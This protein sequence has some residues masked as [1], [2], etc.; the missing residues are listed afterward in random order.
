VTLLPLHQTTV[1]WVRFWDFPRL[2]ICAI[3]LGLLVLVF[4]YA[5]PGWIRLILAA[6]LVAALGEQLRRIAPYTRIAKQESKRARLNRPESR[7]SIL[8]S[9]VLMGNRNAAPLLRHVHESEPDL[10]LLLEPDRWWEEQLRQLEASYLHSIKRPLDNTYGMLLYSRLR[11]SEIEINDLLLPDVPSFFCKVHL[12]DGAA[13]DLHCLHPLPPNV[14]VHTMDRDAEL[15]I[16]GRRVR[17]S[18]AASI[19]A[20]DLNDVA[21]SYTTT[22]FQKLSR[23]LDPRAGRGFFNTYHAR[24]P[25]LRWPLDHLFHSPEFRLVSLDRLAPIGSDHFPILAVLS[26]EPERSEQQHPPQLEHEDREVAQDKIEQAAAENM[27]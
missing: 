1:W 13:V 2:Q 15:V 19:V 17:E 25:F 23:H 9:N 3:A 7:L 12:R 21:W 14:G 5:E 20:G 22:L 8:I 4:I 11:L 16:I 27:L 24:W 10:V 6:V 26:H 18:G